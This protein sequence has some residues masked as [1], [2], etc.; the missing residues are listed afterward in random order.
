LIFLDI[1]GCTF[2]ERPIATVSV[3]LWEPVVL[4]FW[5]FGIWGCLDI[6]L[7]VVFLECLSKGGDFGCAKLV[8]EKGWKIPN[9]GGISNMAFDHSGQLDISHEY[10]CRRRRSCNSESGEDSYNQESV[11]EVNHDQTSEG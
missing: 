3:F 8:V 1:T 6:G 10:G 2:I 11:V 5:A 9:N 4:L 7:N